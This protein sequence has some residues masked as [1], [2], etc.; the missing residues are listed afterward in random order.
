MVANDFTVHLVDNQVLARA[1][2]L[3]CR[4]FDLKE[5][6]DISLTQTYCLPLADGRKRLLTVHLVYAQVLARASSLFLSQLW[7]KGKP[8]YIANFWKPNCLP[9]EGWSQTTFYIAFVVY[10]SITRN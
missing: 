10:A 1:S 7:S 8:W 2:S 3:F 9:R 6:L 4:S 5:N